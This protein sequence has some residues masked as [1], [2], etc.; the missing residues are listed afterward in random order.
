MASLY[1]RTLLP[2]FLLC[3]HVCECHRVQFSLTVQGCDLRSGAG[4]LCFVGRLVPMFSEGGGDSVFLIDGAVRVSACLCSSSWLAAVPKQ[5][6]E[7]HD[8]LRD[9][10]G[11]PGVGTGSASSLSSLP[12]VDSWI[13][14]HVIVHSC[15]MRC[16][17]GEL[18]QQGQLL[19]AAW[20][21]RSWC[22]ASSY[23]LVML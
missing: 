19:P 3:C 21:I 4:I 8:L 16:N 14:Q 9:S 17:S 22:S 20:S 5:H 2:L 6:C 23:P 10:L 15:R 18:A 7:A 13:G 1:F 11:S 12:G